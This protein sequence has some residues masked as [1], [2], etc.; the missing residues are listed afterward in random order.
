MPTRC[1]KLGIRSVLRQDYS[2]MSP[3][4]TRAP[5]A[6]RY[7]IPVALL[8]VVLIIIFWKE[9][10]AASPMFLGYRGKDLFGIY[11]SDL[12]GESFK[13]ILLDERREMTHARISPDGQHLTFTR[14]NRALKD[15]LCEENGSG[16]LHTEVIVANA[17]G[18]SQRS[19]DSVGPEIMSANSSWVDDD[20]IIYIHKAGLKVLPELRIYQLSTG[21]HRRV[22]TP[23]NLAVSD[24]ACSGNA[25]VFPVIPLENDD[26]PCAL[27]TC[28]LDGTGLRQITKP[29]IKPTSRERLFK[30]GDYD[31]WLSYDG[32]SVVFMRYFGAMD[33]RIF[34]VDLSG[35]EKV[36]TQP[37]IPSGIPKFDEYAKIVTFVC[38]D[39][40][41]LENLGLYTLEI[42]GSNRRKIPLPAGY[43]YT[44][45]SFMPSSNSNVV[46]FSGRRVPG[47]PG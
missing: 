43:L 25:I 17:D 34:I 40:T 29:V 7:L 24:P 47:L 42:D 13:T 12:K 19:V 6:L 36:L 15:G 38:W 18:T 23:R 8:T 44:H 33:W 5:K 1:Q 39:K 35:N 41:R 46:I 32:K 4:T 22:A 21:K 14:Y 16:Y 37:G 27:W 20:S 10:V 45:P 30:L 2:A 9:L 11:T 3:P 28:N 26:S 31:P